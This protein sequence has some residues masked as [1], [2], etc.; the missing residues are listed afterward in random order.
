MWFQ[1][2]LERRCVGCKFELYAKGGCWVLFEENCG[3]EILRCPDDSDLLLRFGTIEFDVKKLQLPEMFWSEED[4]ESLI[5]PVSQKKHLYVGLDGDSYAL[6][7]DVICFCI[8]CLLRLEEFDVDFSAD[9]HGRFQAATSHAARYNYLEQP[10]V[11]QLIIFL[12]KLLNRTG[13]H[14]FQFEKKISLRL[15]HDVDAPYFF[16]TSSLVRSLLSNFKN[17]P[18]I[19]N[20]TSIF[21]GIAKGLLLWLNAGRDPYEEDPYN[22]FPWLLKY[23]EKMDLTATF[24]FMGY[25]GAH[26]VDGNYKLNDPRIRKL[27][28]GILRR[29]H[30]IGA[31]YSYACMEEAGRLKQNITEF[32]DY[33]RQFFVND[34]VDLEIRGHF[35]RWKPIMLREI[36]QEKQQLREHTLGYAQRIGFRSG[37][38]I[39]Y[40]INVPGIT[41]SPI[42]I[43]PLSLM[44]C[45]LMDARYMN[46]GTGAQA[47]SKV[48]EI[49]D[50]V[51]QV[52]GELSVLWHNERLSQS[53]ERKLFTTIID[54]VVH[55]GS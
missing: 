39:P 13:V 29:G 47:T 52:D 9:E 27:V 45:S 25:S 8:R 38:S 48:L 53:A 7:G 30:K 16:E 5:L 49:I 22:T 3:R 2:F 43:I 18:S 14:D 17:S 15:S 6:D 11:D 33:R 21:S 1:E 51:R 44:D 10:V 32:I 34:S 50:S 46:L 37:T 23:Y 19:G 28:A 31:H 42:T 41:N 26:P 4:I 54:F 40:E 36:S 55:D 12:K 20:F 35:L 24:F